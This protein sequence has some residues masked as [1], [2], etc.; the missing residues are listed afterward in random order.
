MNKYQENYYKDSIKPT[1]DYSD[2]I[3]E[4]VEVPTDYFVDEWCDCGNPKKAQETYCNKCQK[5][6]IDEFNLL[7][8]KHFSRE[9]LEFLEEVLDGL[10]LSEFIFGKKE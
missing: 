4:N 1:L 2:A 6:I 8:R 3:N 9:D 10:W 5:E 7:M